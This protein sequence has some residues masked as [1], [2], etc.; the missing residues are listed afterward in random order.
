MGRCMKRQYAKKIALTFLK[1]N[2]LR[3]ILLFQIL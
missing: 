3:N 2:L 1:E